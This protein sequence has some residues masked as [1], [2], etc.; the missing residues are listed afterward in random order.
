MTRLLASAAACLALALFAA[1]ATFAVPA[2][3]GI[4]P[5]AMDGD[6][7]GCKG[8]EKPAGDEKPA[9]SSVAPAAM[10]DCGGCKGKDKGGDKGDTAPSTSSV[11]IDMGKDCDGCK[12]KDKD[13]GDKPAAS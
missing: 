9:T 6:C 1:P 5:I 4:A 3:S 11:A 2:V 7:G 12:G 8:K 13:K 10:G